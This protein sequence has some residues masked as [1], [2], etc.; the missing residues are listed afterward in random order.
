[1]NEREIK[2][3]VWDEEMKVM[4][5]DTFDRDK[6]AML[7]DCFSYD[8]HIHMQYTGLKDKN[9]IEI[10]EGDIVKIWIKNLTLSMDTNQ[11]SPRNVLGFRPEYIEIVNTWNKK[12][13][14]EISNYKDIE[15]LEVI[16][17]IYEHP[18]LLEDK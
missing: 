3:R 18:H 4:L 11:F 9:G 6:F 1:M 13:F 10:Y 12:G 5:D 16:G 7:G 8:E 17:N 2:F 15:K 14:W